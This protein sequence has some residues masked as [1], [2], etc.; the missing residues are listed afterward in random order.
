MGRN[1]DPISSR[2]GNRSIRKRRRKKGDTALVHPRGRLWRPALLLALTLMTVL[3]PAAALANSAPPRVLGDTGG[4]LLPG[5]SDQVHVLKESLSFDLNADFTAARVVARYELENRGPA[6]DGQEFVFVVQEHEKD[7][8]LAVS[9]RGQPVPVERV[10]PEQYTPEEQQEMESK[11]TTVDFWMDPVTGERYGDKTFF[12]QAGTQYFRF[13]VDMPSDVSGELVVSYSQAG[14][15]DRTLHVHN[16]YHYQYLL[17]PARGWASFGPLEI[18][19]S[20]PEGSRYYF[21]AN[22][23]FRWEGGAYV[24][25]LPGLPEENLTFAVMDRRG[26]LFGLTQPGPYYWMGFAIVLLLAAAVG[27]GMGRLAAR[28][29]SR[30]WASPVGAL[31]GLVVGGALDVLMAAFVLGSIPALREQSYGL[32]FAGVGQG[33]VGAVVTAIAAGYTA[34]RTWRR[35]DAKG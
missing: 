5:E 24:A 25:E 28:L 13:A 4:P 22:L 33:L 8:N 6:I 1:V 30:S 20:A 15:N 10:D 17:L 29:P 9:W 14:A 2:R 34:Q 12:G 26:L 27:L 23:G 21:A 35:R 31:G 16:V 7:L 18:R 19:V 11:W 3:W 32:I